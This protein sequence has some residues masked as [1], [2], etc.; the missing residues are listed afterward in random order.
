MMMRTDRIWRGVL[1]VMSALVVCAAAPV[2]GQAPVDDLGAPSPLEQALMEHACRGSGQANVEIYEACL[3]G[4]LQLLR[5]D[6]GRDLQKLTTADRRAIDARCAAV[7]STR[8]RDAYI[9]CMN[10]QIIAMRARRA[11]PAA[12]A[13]SAAVPTGE[14]EAPSAPAPLTPANAEPAA[15]PAAPPAP[16]GSSQMVWIGLAMIAAAGAGGGWWA[17]NARQPRL[18][19]HLC[20]T[21]GADVPAA[22]ELCAACRHEAAEELRRAAAERAEQQRAL[23]EDAKRAHDEADARARQAVEEANLAQARAREAELERQRDEARRREEEHRQWQQAAAAAIAAPAVDDEAF[24]P[25]AVLGVAKTAGEAE[26]RAAYD[27][28]REKYSGDQI[29]HLGEELQGHFRAK[30]KA[31]ER[32]YEALTSPARA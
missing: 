2:S 10:E 15:P 22:G 13:A 9:G 28:R 3:H 16:E 12:A 21:C 20:R 8:G 17:L 31:V 19:V 4:Q 25:H 6:F 7:R 24:D 18:Q 5:A 23:A 1:G 30:A 32:A 14:A 27:E 11:K 29:A 26:I